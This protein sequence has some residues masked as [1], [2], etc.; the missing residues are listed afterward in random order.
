MRLGR[1]RTLETGVRPGRDVRIEPPT[2]RI[3][4][5]WKLTREP[6]RLR[7]QDIVSPTTHSGTDRTEYSFSVNKHRTGRNE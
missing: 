6:V 4:R 2:G 3:D 5:R 7:Y 1:T